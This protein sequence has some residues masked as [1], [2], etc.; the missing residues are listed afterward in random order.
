MHDGVDWQAAARGLDEEGYARIPD[1]LA[2]SECDDLA[3]IWD[4]DEAFRKHISMERHR[5]GVG[6]YKYFSYPLPEPVE[7]LRD[8]LYSEL[9]PLANA[10]CERL[11]VE[12]RYPA[13]L[14]EFTEECHAN[15]QLR[16]TPLLLRYTEGGFNC[17]HQ[18]RYGAVGFPMQVAVLLSEPGV[19]FEGG[20]FLLVEQRPRQQSRGEAIVLRKGEAIV[21]PNQL[22][23]THG[24][25]GTV[26]A[27]VRHGVS[28][29]RH[30]ERY[31][32]GIIFHDAE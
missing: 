4:R 10:W 16:P 23:P 8:W 18:D 25:R 29:L 15:G 19:D 24:A 28:R 21:F 1:L 2:P 22:R 26:R 12:T 7:G 30:G 5:Y 20:E 14:S 13:R 3:A 9:A 11:R 32:L 27:A 17:L 6:D 31:A